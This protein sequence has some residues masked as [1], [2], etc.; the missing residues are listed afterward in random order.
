MTSRPRPTG[1]TKSRPLSA[2]YIGPASSPNLSS[3]PSIPDLPE[4]PS[5]TSSGGSGL[6][7]PPASNSTGSGSTNAGSIRQRPAQRKNGASPDAFAADMPN[8]TR[9][10]ERSRSRAGSVVDDDDPYEHENDE[11]NTARFVDGRRRSL[12]DAPADNMT[13]LQRVKSLTQRNRMVSA[14]QCLGRVQCSWKTPQFAFYT[15]AWF[16]IVLCNVRDSSP[17][18]PP[19]AIMHASLPYRQCGTLLTSPP[20]FHLRP[21][22]H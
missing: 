15:D 20:S 14:M 7:S 11:D 17:Y 1:G 21:R 8:G 9:T 2:I 10:E 5:P 4:P 13:A 3:P 22:I 6:P 12:K 16:S 18:T 19:L